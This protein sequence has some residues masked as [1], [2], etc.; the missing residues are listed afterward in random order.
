MGQMMWQTCVG[1]KNIFYFNN[2]KNALS[3]RILKI[4]LKT[5]LEITQKNM[6]A[7]FES[8]RSIKNVSNDG[9]NLRWKNFF[10]NKSKKALRN[11][12]SKI[13]LK[14][15]LENTQKNMLAKFESNLSIR[16]VSNDGANSCWKKKHFLF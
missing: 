10:F 13:S 1:R 2:S 9:A 14:M 6:H 4:S 16:N 8:N 11:R 5:S 3:N 12:I 15:S 7:K